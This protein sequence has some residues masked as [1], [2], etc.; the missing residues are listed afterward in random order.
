MSDYDL[1]VFDYNVGRAMGMDHW[2]C[3]WAGL[4]WIGQR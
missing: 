3:I 2:D 4:A 1:F